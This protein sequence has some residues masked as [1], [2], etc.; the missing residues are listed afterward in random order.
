MVANFSSFRLER[1]LLRSQK[2]IANLRIEEAHD[3]HGSSS[4]VS[5][6]LQIGYLCLMEIQT[7]SSHMIIKQLAAI[8][9]LNLWKQLA[10]DWILVNFE[11][12]PYLLL[13]ENRFIDLREADHNI[14]NIAERRLYCSPAE[15][16]G[17][18]M[19]RGVADIPPPAQ[20]DWT[21]TLWGSILI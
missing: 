1:Q 8:L 15:R 2:R 17:A 3:R 4:K 20:V 5:R 16:R 14:I 18:V 12:V 10:L 6:I 21:L 11:R 13:Q 9:Y 7:G 19:D